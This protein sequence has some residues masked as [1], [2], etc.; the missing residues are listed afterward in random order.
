MEWLIALGI[1]IIIWILMIW[2]ADY[3]KEDKEKLRKYLYAHRGLHSKEKKIPENSLAAFDAACEAGYGSELD[4]HF[5]KDKQIVVFHDDTLKRMCGADVRVDDL[6]YEE[7]Q[8]YTL[9]GTDQKIPLFTEVLDLVNGRTPLVVE[10][11]N[12]KMYKEL[13]E[14]TN[15]I[16]NNYKGDFCIESFNPMIV[17]KYAKTNPMVHRGLLVANHVRSKSLNFFLGFAIQEMLFNF[18]ARPQFIACHHGAL[19][20]W[21]VKIVRFLFKPVMA[22]WTIVNEEQY[23]KVK[24]LDI[25]IFEQFLPDP[26]RPELKETKKKKK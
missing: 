24:D 21:G 17:R 1:I 26:T 23:E 2:P 20:M 13:V 11:K 18:I 5:S 6:T 3:I 19:S 4:I 10:L 12:T 8:E 25:I 22:T 16:L 15:K 7:M 9:D 14:E